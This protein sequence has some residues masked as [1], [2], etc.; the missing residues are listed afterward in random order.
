MIYI[1]IHNLEYVWNY[2][3]LWFPLHSHKIPELIFWKKLVVVPEM[4]HINQAD[5]LAKTK[6]AQV[7]ILV[8]SQ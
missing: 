6:E 4:H 5:R 8:R 2:F 7:N 1:Y 3:F